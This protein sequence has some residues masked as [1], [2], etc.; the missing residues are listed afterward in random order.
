MDK[1][2]IYTQAYNAED[3]LERAIESVLKQTNG[4]FLYY[5]LDNGSNDRTGEII[6]EYANKDNRIIPLANEVNNVWLKS[7]RW[8]SFLKNHEGDGWFS[9]LDA[10]DE[11][12]SDFLEKMINFATENNLDVATCGTDW[13]DE[14]NGN[15]MKQKVLSENMILEDQDFAEQFPVYR[16]YMVTIWG[17][18][19]SLALLRK[20]KLNWSS[21]IKSFSD[22][23]FCMEAFRRA[24]RAGIFAESLHKYYVQPTTDSYKYYPKWFLY[25]KKLIEASREYLLDYGKISKQNEDYLYALHLILIKYILP[26]IQNADIDYSR[27]IKGLH[28]IFNDEMTQYMLTH[29]TEVGIYSD[30]AEFLQEIKDW[31][32]S[33]KVREKYRPIINEVIVAIQCGAEGKL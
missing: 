32:T 33:Q 26:R 9:T 8:L 19:Y 22:T 27:K 23:G 30:K 24:N 2:I 29:W 12:T 1:I 31:I 28:E 14:K 4:N 3:T 7:N 5:V 15:L 6:A 21:C 18:V 25:S 16:N 10:D 20:I 17:A 11:Y 13:I